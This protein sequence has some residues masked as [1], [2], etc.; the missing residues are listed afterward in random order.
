MPHTPPV[1]QAFAPRFGIVGAVAPGDLR[2]TVKRVLGAPVPRRRARGATILL[3]H[4]VGG[5][6]GNELDVAT[7]A[8]EQQLDVLARHRVVSLDA[9]LDALAA[10]DD[11]PCVVLTFDDG[12]G[13]VYANAWPRLRERQ[14]PFTVY[15]ASAYMGGVMGW[16]GR[17][18]PALLWDELAEMQATGLCTVGNHGHTH[19]LPADLSVDELARCSD[20]V[21][22]A[23]GE[24]PRH[25]AYPW[26]IEVADLRVEVA[27]RFRS[28]A[29]G[30]V[31]RN[32]PGA[33]LMAL[34]RI[35][36]RRTDPIVFFRAKLA[37]RLLPER[38]YGAL[39]GAAK[40]VVGR[41]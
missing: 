32:V 38:G 19:P 41:G 34:R 6:S 9:A 8:F 20:T 1:N 10:G 3:Y 12:W 21:E 39:V 40:R 23:L 35:P 4:R 28:A 11:S 13:D 30:V 29:T 22:A 25:F 15:L 24:R 36:V 33:D 18:A 7:A 2:T 27:A 26:G 5:T 31:G 37:G 16:S 17:H 14:L